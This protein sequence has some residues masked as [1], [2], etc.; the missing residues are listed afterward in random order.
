MIALQSIDL[1]C[2]NCI[3]K[4]ALPVAQ[5]RQ[6]HSTQ[7]EHDAGSHASCMAG[8]D[9]HVLHMQ[10]VLYCTRQ[11]AAA[12]TPYSQEVTECFVHQ[13]RHASC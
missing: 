13:S 12:V 10:D 4:V 7:Q 6:M 11:N 9:F 1:A 5:S 2:T 8:S 3:T